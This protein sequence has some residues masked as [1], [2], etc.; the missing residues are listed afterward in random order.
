MRRF[1]LVGR[2]GPDD[3]ATVELLQL[4]G[5]T[6]DIDFLDPDRRLAYGIGQAVH[7]LS[8]FGLRPPETAVDLMVVAALV[9]AGDTRISRKA[10]AQDG[11]TREIDLYVPVSDPKPWTRSADHL[12]GL[13]KFLTGDRW[14]LI[15][16][17][18]P[19]RAR[20][21]VP[22]PAQLGLESFDGVSLF[23]GGLD[24]LVG[25]VDHLAAGARPLFVSHYWDGETAKAQAY[26]LKALRRRFPDPEVRAL[27]VRLGFGKRDL[28]TG[29]T[30]NTQRGRSFLF[31][32]MASF[33]AA[34]FGRQTSVTIPENGL[35]ALNVPLDSLR[36]GALSTRTAHPHFIAGMGRLLEMIGLPVTLLNPYRHRTKG[37]MVATCRDLAFLHDV[38]DA[39]MSCSAPAKFRFKGLPP[40]H[41]GY[42]VP[43]LIRRASLDTGLGAPD[44]T[45]YY[46]K[47]LTGRTLRSDRPEGEHVRAF[48]LM[49]RRLGARPELAKILV[50]KP[51]PL[52]DVPGELPAY[53]EVFG[54]GVS[55]VSKMLGSARTTPA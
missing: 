45:V 54:R 18:R 26:L 3:D 40:Q 38:V 52:T 10:N 37:E 50:H 25:A 27:R 11:W 49:A 41:C 4:D 32:A 23:S 44:P 13:L 2:L 29:E 55:E 9:N 53:V 21:L 7:Q 31:Y 17:A 22:A 39:S 34:S 6:F 20:A 28:D 35:I 24:S 14:R 42:C 19:R 47:D 43:C 46:I 15:F 8:A 12:A 33:A 36:L 1:G 5:A 51:G 16:R 30:E 48:Q